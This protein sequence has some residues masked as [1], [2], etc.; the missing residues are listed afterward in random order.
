MKKISLLIIIPA[1]LFLVSCGR[2]NIPQQTTTTP[3][4]PKIAPD[5]INQ[6]QY[7]KK[8]VILNDSTTTNN[9]KNITDS[10]NSPDSAAANVAAANNAAALTAPLVVIDSHGM[11]QVDSTNLPSGVSHNL[12]SLSQSVRAFT[13]DQAKN[14]AHR[15]NDIPPRVLLVPD[16]LAKKGVK[17][18]YYKYQNKFWYWKKD[19]GFFYLDE[20]YYQ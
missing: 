7:V 13:P 17:G 15:F 4:H 12:D 5:R 20:N 16:N 11:L 8:A 2:R 3:V 10:Y 18:Y 1:I 19:D 6:Q 14:L 9:P